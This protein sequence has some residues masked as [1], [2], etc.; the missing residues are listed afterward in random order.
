MEK[1]VTL[2]LHLSEDEIE[3]IAHA[4]LNL[5]GDHFESIGKARR[6]PVDP[7]MPVIGEELAIARSLQ[8]L[9]GQIMEAAQDK[10]E[11]FLKEG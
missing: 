9:T 11:A 2:N 5:R 10:V 8:T 7:P 1:D 6:N 4:V 3:T